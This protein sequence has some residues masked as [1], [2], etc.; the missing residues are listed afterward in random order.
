MFKTITLLLLGLSGWPLWADASCAN[1]PETK[2]T[3]CMPDAVYVYLDQKTAIAGD[4]SV[5]VVAEVLSRAR[6]NVHDETQVTFVLQREDA[7]VRQSAQTQAGI[8]AAAL[9]VGTKSGPAYV[10]AEVEGVKSTK[11]GIRILPDAPAS[12]R[13]SFEGCKSGVS[14]QVEASDIRDSFGNRVSDGIAGTLRTYA[15]DKLVRQQ[16]VHTLRGSS[17]AK[18]SPLLRDA[19]IELVFG[20]ASVSLEVAAQ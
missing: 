17:Q 7:T 16:T 13:L 19:R 9:D 3:A 8:A 6:T 1:L 18:W 10:W 14:C 5:L 4:A 15:N 2:A 11:Q 12:F 20:S